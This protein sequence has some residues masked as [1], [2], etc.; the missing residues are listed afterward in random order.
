MGDFFIEGFHIHKHIIKKEITPHYYEKDIFDWH[1]QVY[2][3][4]KFLILPDKF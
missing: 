1:F 4:I 3:F 2:I